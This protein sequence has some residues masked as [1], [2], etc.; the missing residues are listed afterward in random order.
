MY[1]V[2][3]KYRNIRSEIFC[4]NKKEADMWLFEQNDNY[5]TI[6]IKKIK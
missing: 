6:V 4:E 5:D 3:V 1:K 2:I